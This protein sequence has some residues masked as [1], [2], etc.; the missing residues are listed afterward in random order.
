MYLLNM[1]LYDYPDI[2][3]YGIFT[4]V[5]VFSKVHIGKSPIHGAFGLLTR[6]AFRLRIDSPETDFV[7][8]PVA[9]HGDS[10]N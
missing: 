6:R 5:C 4:Y 8:I 3:M 1:A 2:Y 7:S 10:N 9:W